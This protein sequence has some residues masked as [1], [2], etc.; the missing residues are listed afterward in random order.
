[1]NLRE[2]IRKVLR[3]DNTHSEDVLSKMINKRILKK[4]EYPW[5]EKLY[6]VE[7]KEED[8]FHRGM[9]RN[10]WGSRILI[11]IKPEYFANLSKNW[12]NYTSKEDMFIYYGSEIIR[13]FIDKSYESQPNILTIEIQDLAERIGFEPHYS[14][15][16]IYFVIPATEEEI[17]SKPP[18]V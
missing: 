1:V 11:E 10:T 18:Y 3:E 2:T 14:L 15:F 4:G 5:V 6:S 17:N 7:L 9:I 13:R 12:G 16:N 8:E